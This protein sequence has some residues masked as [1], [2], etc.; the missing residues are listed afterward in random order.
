[1]YKYLYTGMGVAGIYLLLYRFASSRLGVI[2]TLLYASTYHI[3]NILAWALMNQWNVCIEEPHALVPLIK[4]L[5][6]TKLPAHFQIF[7][8]PNT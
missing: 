1:M 4:L 7:Q 3:H 2:H 5:N 8:L 6:Y